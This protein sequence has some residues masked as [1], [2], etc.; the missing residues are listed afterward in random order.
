MSRFGQMLENIQRVKSEGFDPTQ[1]TYMER[2]KQQPPSPLSNQNKQAF[3]SYLDKQGIE[4]NVARS[5]KL[6]GGEKEEAYILNT[7]MGG[8]NYREAVRQGKV[9]LSNWNEVR[10]PSLEDIAQDIKQK[11]D[12]WLVT[13]KAKSYVPRQVLSTTTDFYDPEEDAARPGMRDVDLRGESMQGLI[14]QGKA[15][16]ANEIANVPDDDLQQLGVDR[17]SLYREYDIPKEMWR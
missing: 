17:A 15:K 2:M 5:G 9:S 3:E 11:G 8:E 16:L 13:G 6:M 14:K 1:E 12:K 7:S 10:D 4:T